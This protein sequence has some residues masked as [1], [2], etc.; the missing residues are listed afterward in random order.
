MGDLG[1]MFGGL[2]MGR[3]DPANMFGTRG[4]F[5]GGDPSVNGGLLNQALSGGNTPQQQGYGIGDVG[6][7]QQYRPN[8][9]IQQGGY[10]QK[11]DISGPGAAESFW[12][13]MKPQAQLPELPGLDPYYQRA[14]ERT[15]ADVNKQIG[16]RGMFGSSV[17]LDQLG[18][19]LGGLSA[20]QANREAQYALDRQR[21]QQSQ[22]GLMGQL[23]GQAQ[24]A[25]QGRI[26]D[27]WNYQM[28]LANQLAAP[29]L[30]QMNRLSEE[31]QALLQAALH[32]ETGLAREAANQGYRTEERIWS[33]A[34]RGAG[35]FGNLLGGIVGK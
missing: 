4:P 22:T 15:A 27:L 16:A 3:G 12:Q 20:E 33:D 11:F 9:G 32:P 19:A 31:D 24:A 25:Q 5:N 21:G 6:P 2:G 7:F 23:A 26:G 35:L 13:Q 18:N 30:D 1:S 17:G 29:Y 34:E 10:N 14:R 8:Q 28:S